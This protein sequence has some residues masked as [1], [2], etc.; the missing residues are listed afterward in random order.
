MKKL[1]RRNKIACLL[2]QFLVVGTPGLAFAKFDSQD[3]P[4]EVVR[5]AKEGLPRF[6]DGVSESSLESFGFAKGDSAAKAVLD[7]PFKL[8]ML[9]PSDVKTYAAG[10]PIEPL[11]VET[12]QWYFPVLIGGQTRAFFVVDKVDGQWRAVSLG[13]GDLAKEMGKVRGRWPQSKGYHP[14]YIALPSAYEFFVTVPE[15]GPDNLTSLMARAGGSA[16]YKE[17]DRAADVVERVKPLLEKKH[18]H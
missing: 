6:L 12:E 5:A 3:P 2:L 17:L 18:V 10:A 7:A 11:A 16:D 4:P 1:A 14:R 8:Y 13:Y 15:M 9:R